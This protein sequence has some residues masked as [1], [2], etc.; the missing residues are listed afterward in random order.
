MAKNLPKETGF[1]WA[2][3]DGMQWF[4]AIVQVYGDSPFFKV[5]GWDH[6]REKTFSGIENISE[7]GNKIQEQD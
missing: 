3:T 7:F 1:Y 2:K 5:I 4:N 6:R